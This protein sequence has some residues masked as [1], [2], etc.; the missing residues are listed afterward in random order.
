[1]KGQLNL[2]VLF[3]V[4]SLGFLSNDV[5]A[6]DRIDFDKRLVT[7]DLNEFETA[8]ELLVSGMSIRLDDGVYKT[9]SSRGEKFFDVYLDTEAQTLLRENTSLRFRK[10]FIKGNLVKQMLQLKR[11]KRLIDGSLAFSEEKTTFPIKSQILEIE[12]I[13]DLMKKNEHLKGSV[14]NLVGERLSLIK[15]V[16]LLHV[17]QTRNRFYLHDSNDRRVYTITFD[18]VTSFNSIN[19]IIDYFV[20]IELSEKIASRLGQVELKTKLKN[21]SELKNM[22]LK[23]FREIN[24]SKLYFSI[25]KMNLKPGHN[26]TEDSIWA[27]LI[28]GLIL[29]VGVIAYKTRLKT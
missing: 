3:L 2:L 7:D 6:S 23:N 10:R 9:F 12:T 16:P 20:E 18:E 5:K 21:I 17:H 29:I 22:F 1:M 15:L 27:F 26:I 13:L 25:K 19:F 11:P 4:G 24:D 8:Q 28:I 14:S